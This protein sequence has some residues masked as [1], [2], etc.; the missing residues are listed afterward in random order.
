[1]TAPPSPPTARCPRTAPRL[2]PARAAALLAAAALAPMFTSGCGGEPAAEPPPPRPV[3]WVEVAAGGGGVTRTLAGVAR[4][5]VESRLS[6]RVGGTVRELAVEVGDRVRR[7]A[8]LARLDPTDYELKVEEAEAARAQAEAAL[9]KA[10]ADYDRVRALYENNNASKSDLDAARAA[11]ESATAQVEAGDKRLAQARQQVGYT[12][13]AAPLDG[14]IAEVEVEVNE[15][16]Q[17]G[18][19]VVLL[20][21]V[22]RPE[23]AVAVP[24]GLIARLRQGQPVTVAFDA[25]PGREFAATLAEVGVAATGN[26]TTFEVTARLAE[27]DPEIRS[28]MAADVTFRFAPE[29]EGPLVVPG[30]AVG[31]DREGRFVFVLE[32]G[33]EA[34]T[35]TVRRRTVT[36]GAPVEGGL[37]LLAGVEPGER[38]VTA[39]VRRLT[40]GMAVRLLGPEGGGG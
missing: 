32:A 14:A 18:Q 35:G 31:E 4:A 29:R 5:G 33:G 15:N 30:V 7:G 20:T 2:S 12:V 11:A 38:L 28:G 9:R 3:R 22:A 24:E 39:G 23:V 36:V 13:L 26:A 40:D 25:L 10:E 27:P 17:P 19:R 16:V 37:E 34:G 21:S 1:M 6:F 8:V